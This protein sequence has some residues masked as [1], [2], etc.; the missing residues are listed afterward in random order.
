MD[1]IRA[2]YL[3]QRPCKE[4]RKCAYV[5]QRQLAPPTEWEESSHLGSRVPGLLLSLPLRQNCF[6]NDGAVTKLPLSF[7]LPP[8]SFQTAAAAAAAAA[9]VVVVAVPAH[10]CSG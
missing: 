6:M 8:D 9:A 4:R 1:A 3:M 2:A 10:E 7:F 5:G